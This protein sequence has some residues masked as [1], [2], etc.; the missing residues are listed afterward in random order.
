[1][2]YSLRDVTKFKKKEVSNRYAHTEEQKQ[3]RQKW[4]RQET[5]KAGEAKIPLR[6][7]TL[8]NIKGM[9]KR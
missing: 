3:G 8:K 9:E 6:K 1:M 2:L 5:D 4:K 7:K